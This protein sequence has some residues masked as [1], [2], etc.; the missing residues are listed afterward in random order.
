MKITIIC[1]TIRH[2]NEWIDKYKWSTYV[3][4]L[5]Y[6]K[7]CIFLQNPC[8]DVKMLFILLLIFCLENKFEY[9]FAVL[10]NLSLFSSPSHFSNSYF[11]IFNCNCYIYMPINTFCLYHFF[12]FI[13]KKI[14]YL[15]RTH[16]VQVTNNGMYDVNPIFRISSY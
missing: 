8:F 14:F 4:F 3:H 16:Y 6:I 10:P 1:Q 2:F 5:E 13:F 12:L 11:L 9:W 15:Y 7:W